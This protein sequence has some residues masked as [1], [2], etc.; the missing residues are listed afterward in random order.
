MGELVVSDTEPMCMTLPA[1]ARSCGTARPP[2]VLVCSRLQWVIRHTLFGGLL[3]GATVVVVTKH[4]AVIQAAQLVVAM[5]LGRVA[6]SGSPAAYADWRAQHSH[7]QQQQQQ[8]KGG[9]SNGWR[10][11]VR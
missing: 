10:P 11:L 4:P 5:Q 2:L 1:T 8:A 6:F 9:G 7:Y 3:S